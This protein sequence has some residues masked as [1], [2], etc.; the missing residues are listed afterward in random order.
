MYS[1][2]QRCCGSGFIL[3]CLA[4]GKSEKAGTPM[5]TGIHTHTHTQ[6]LTL[7]FPSLSFTIMM[8]AMDFPR[9]FREKMTFL[10]LLS[11]HQWRWWVRSE[12]KWENLFISILRVTQ[13]S[14]LSLKRRDPSHSIQYHSSDTQQLTFEA[15]IAVLNITNVLQ[16]KGT[17]AQTIS[18]THQNR[19][20]PW[21]YGSK[22]WPELK[23][24][25]P[26]IKP[27]VRYVWVLE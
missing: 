12:M 13:L 5:T 24:R 20:T 26:C 23:D 22:L 1:Q 14:H 18:S 4:L 3:V 27:S 15:L 21:H 6:C 19:V 2:F 17:H 8:E 16:R 9:I 7:T 11:H 25:W 10:Y